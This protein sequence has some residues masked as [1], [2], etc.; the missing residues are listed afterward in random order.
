MADKTSTKRTKALADAGA[1]EPKKK[2][3]AAQLGK[4]KQ[5]AEAQIDEVLRRMG[6]PNPAEVIDEEGWRRMAIG[7]ALGRVGVLAAGEELYLAVI[8]PIMDVPSDGDLIVPLMHDLLEFNASAIAS[9]RLGIAGKTVF[10]S[11]MWPLWAVGPEDIASAIISVMSTA[12]DIDDKLKAKY[13]GTSKKRG[14]ASK[15]AAPAAKAAAAKS[16]AKAPSKSK[17]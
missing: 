16:G 10:A 13:G 7:S 6:L 1:S 4:M 17:K 9:P 3:S 15:A 5:A 11:V 12:D 14:G 2:P 8:A